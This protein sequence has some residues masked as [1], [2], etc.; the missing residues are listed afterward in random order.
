MEARDIVEG[1][2]I[3]GRVEG[4]EVIAE[5]EGVRGEKGD[6]GGMVGVSVAEDGGRKGIGRGGEVVG[7]IGGEVVET[8]VELIGGGESEGT[9]GD[10]TERVKGLVGGGKGGIVVGG[11]GVGA[12]SFVCF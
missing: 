5:S 12:I 1:V 2:V 7:I 3:E 10:E 6:E 9:E 4:V 11:E 8:V